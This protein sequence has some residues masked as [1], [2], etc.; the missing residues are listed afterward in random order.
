VARALGAIEGEGG[1]LRALTRADG[2]V[3]LDDSYNANRASVVA[4][5][6]TAAELA[7]AEGRRLVAVL[8]EMREL[9]A[10]SADEHRIVGEEAARWA[11]VVVAVQGD[12]AEIARA[13]AAA[14]GPEVLFVPDAA[15]ATDEVSARL[16]P[17]DLVLVKGSRGVLLDTVVNAL[18]PPEPPR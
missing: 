12:T 15:R 1:R 10:L 13:A 16:R 3:I 4:S 17:G 18:M 9:G 14:G 8:G 2:C 6:R 11:S 7:R 5:L